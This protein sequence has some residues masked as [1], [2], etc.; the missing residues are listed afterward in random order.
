MPAVGRRSARFGILTG[1]TCLFDVGAHAEDAHVV[2][3]VEVVAEVELAEPEGD[4]EAGEVGREACAAVEGY[5]KVGAGLRLAME[6]LRV[7]LSDANR[8]TSFAPTRKGASASAA[9]MVDV[10]YARS[11][12]R[13]WPSASTP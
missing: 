11:E 5:C 1:D 9:A 10:V 4:G 8:K 12:I 2:G 3:V 7:V 13:I 6:S